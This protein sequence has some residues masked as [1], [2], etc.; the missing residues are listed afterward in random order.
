MQVVFLTVLHEATVQFCM[1]IFMNIRNTERY[2]SSIDI[3]VDIVEREL[4][5][6]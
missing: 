4:R 6:N 2:V 5:N 1:N 3:L